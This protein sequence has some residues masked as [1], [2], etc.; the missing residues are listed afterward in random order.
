M[1]YTEKDKNLMKEIADYS[2]Q[3]R[4]HM[5][6]GAT[7]LNKVIEKYKEISNIGKQSKIITNGN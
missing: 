5:T 3:F 2:Q 1:T 6:E 7:A 4:H